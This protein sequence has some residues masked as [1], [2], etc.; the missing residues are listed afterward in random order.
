MTCNANSYFKFK[1]IARP[2][3]CHQT[4]LTG[5]SLVTKNGVTGLDECNVSCNECTGSAINCN[6]CKINYFPKVNVGFPQQCY[7]S[8]PPGFYFH[9]NFYKPCEAKCATCQGSA[10]FYLTCASNYYYT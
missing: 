8:D 10:R 3:T 2:N 6:A 4:P 1:D 9:E 5:F 7:N